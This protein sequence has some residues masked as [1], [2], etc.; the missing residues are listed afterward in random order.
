MTMLTYLDLSTCHV[1]EETMR[2]IERM[3]DAGKRLALHW[4]AMTIA[5][6]D[7]GAFLTVPEFE[8]EDEKRHI[9]KLP[10]DLQAVFDYANLLGATVVRL[11]SDSDVIKGL[12]V[13][14]W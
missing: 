9:Q 8:D 11:N 14:H 3:Q 7:Y 4:P 2:E 6:Y 13:Y 10:F 5:S 12:P 1:Q